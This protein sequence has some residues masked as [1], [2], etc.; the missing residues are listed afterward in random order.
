[1]VRKIQ[2]LNHGIKHEEDISVRKVKTRIFDDEGLNDEFREFAKR[3]NELNFHWYTSDVPNFHSLKIADGKVVYEIGVSSSIEALGFLSL[4]RNRTN[5][6]RILNE[7]RFVGLRNV[8]EQK[9]TFYLTNF[10]HVLTQN[11]LGITEDDEIILL[12][13]SKQLSEGPGRYNVFAGFISSVNEIDGRKVD[14]TEFTKQA[15]A[16][17]SEESGLNHSDINVGR[18]QLTGLVRCLYNSYTP[19]LTWVYRLGN[20]TRDELLETMKKAKKYDNVHLEHDSVLF[21]PLD[22]VPLLFN[23]KSFADKRGVK[24]DPLISED[25][26]S[27]TGIVDDTIGSILSYLRNNNH[28]IF[29]EAKTALEKMGLVVEVIDLVEGEKFTF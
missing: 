5:S 13:R 1:M 14:I 3:N 28:S 12:R 8:I 20:L 24:F 6:L 4:I 22:K 2:I 23:G 17:L 29:E 9:G 10:F 19:G 7:D 27:K 15:I 26:Y 21:L 16:E 11:I 18:L 25:D